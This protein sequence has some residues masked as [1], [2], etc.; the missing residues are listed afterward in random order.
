MLLSIATATVCAVAADDINSS[1]FARSMKSE[2]QSAV[3]S[4]PSGLAQR[5]NQRAIANEL[6]ASRSRYLPEV[7]VFGEVGAEIVDN[8]NSLSANDNDEWKTS[9]QIG[10]SARL[11]L[12]DG[13][14]R[15]NAL[16][17]NAARLDGALY[18]VLATSEAVAL[19]AVEAYID[20]YRHRRLLTIARQNIR[21]H[22]EILRQIRSRVAG[23]KSPASDSFQ[24]E[25]RVYAAQTVEVEIEKA[26]RDAAAK[27]RKSVGRSPSGKMSIPRVRHLPRSV[28]SLIDASVANSYQLKALQ[29]SVSE[30]EYA[31]NVGDAAYM[32]KVHLEG[33]TSIGEDRGGSSGEEHDAFVGLKLSWKLY[34]GGVSYS[35]TNAQAERTGK[36]MYQR[37]VKVREIRETAERSWNSYINDGRRRSLLQSQV[38]TNRKIVK[39]YREEYELSKRTLLDVLDA[40]RARF[41]SEFQQI[42]ATA[43]HQF[44]A[45]RMLATQSKLADYFGMPQDA[46]VPRADYEDQFL[47][48][49][50]RGLVST[51][52]QSIFNIDIAP[53]K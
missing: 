48:A 11:T 12:F 22:R 7:S 51:S 40:E 17:R 8:P 49:S 23:G 34:D 19:N 25:E 36:A 28:A 4:H 5:A 32:P 43:A 47:N 13:Y 9:R 29:K 37:D 6:E 53:L 38:N 46:I 18:S 35:E 1:A 41:N 50:K 15:A 44:S 52:G 27:F 3:K 14:E 42:G 45:F 26:S 33:R 39:N 20:V 24:I 10:V 21:R 30:S 2:V 16:Y 31:E